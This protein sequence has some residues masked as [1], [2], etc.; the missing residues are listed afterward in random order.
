MEIVKQSHALIHSCVDTCVICV[1]VYYS[2]MEK[3]SC[4]LLQ[5]EYGTLK[6]LAEEC[7]GML[8][9]HTVG[10]EE[11]RKVQ[12]QFNKQAEQFQQRL[13][14]YCSFLQKLFS[15]D[16][17]APEIQKIFDQ[18]DTRKAALAAIFRCRED[19]ISTTK[20]EAL[21]GDIVLHDG[22]LNLNL[23]KKLPEEVR[24]PKYVGGDINM[25]GLAK[26][27]EKVQLPEHI[28]GDL[29]L[30][31]LTTLP[32]KV[33]LPKY[34]RGYL[35]LYNLTT[36]PGKVQ[37]PEY[38][39]GGLYLSSLAELPEKVQLPEYIG[40][41]LGLSSLTKLPDD[42][43]FPEHIGGILFLNKKLKGHSALSTIPEGV[44]IEWE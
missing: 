10:S 25:S 24:L 19:Q 30:D 7:R 38:V 27:P 6:T 32:G 29:I 28:G 5:Q 39:G 2:C 18:H 17:E 41:D 44:S 31:K 16:E 43:T 13:A 15:K 40:D 35:F 4:D 8:T 1:K 21:S 20:E 14:E 22:Y 11:Y 42:F 26:L 23:L 37:L 36:L 12:K 3:V 33:Q 9:V 34:V